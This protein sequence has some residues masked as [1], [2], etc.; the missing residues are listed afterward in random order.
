[1]KTLFPSREVN[2]ATW[3]G[4]WPLTI[5]GGVLQL[6][7]GHHVVLVAKQKVYAVN[8]AAKGARHFFLDR[9]R[10]V[11]IDKVWR[12]D[13]QVPGLKVSVGPLIAMGLALGKGDER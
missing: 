11:P 12:D 13:P 9:P 8:G 3:E 2:R 6:R 10:Y 1:M 7:D 5:A 4:E